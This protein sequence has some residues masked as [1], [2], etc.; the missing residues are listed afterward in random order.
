MTRQEAWRIMVSAGSP[1]LPDCSDRYAPA[2][3]ADKIAEC[4][5]IW[6]A[7]YSNSKSKVSLCDLE[8]ERETGCFAEMR[9]ILRGK[10]QLRLRRSRHFKTAWMRF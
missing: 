7:H 9:S 5:F 8:L 6:K 10:A 1:T 3:P 2:P 4:N